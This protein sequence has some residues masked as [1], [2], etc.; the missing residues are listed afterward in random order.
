M[1]KDFT[2]NI[3][4]PWTEITSIVSAWCNGNILTVFIQLLPGLKTGFHIRSNRN[5]STLENFRNC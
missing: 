2:D 3:A 1:E 5:K 4:M